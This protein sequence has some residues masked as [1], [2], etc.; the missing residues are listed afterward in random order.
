MKLT[1]IILNEGINDNIDKISLIYTNHGDFSKL[2]IDG[3]D[4]Y[5]KQAPEVIKGLTGLD[6]PLEGFPDYS[7]VQEVIQ[8]LKAK[9]IDAE[10]YELDVD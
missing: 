2:K 6:L 1:D 5:R 3:K 10:A 7:E 4:Y 8:A 9:G